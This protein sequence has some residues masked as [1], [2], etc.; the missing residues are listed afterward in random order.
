MRMPSPEHH[1]L[2]TL[3]IELTVVAALAATVCTIVMLE[4]RRL[5]EWRGDVIKGRRKPQATASVRNETRLLTA[6]CATLILIAAITF[7]TATVGVIN[8]V[9]GAVA[10]G[11][12]EHEE[13]RLPPNG[14]AKEPAGRQQPTGPG[15]P[16]TDGRNR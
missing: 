8:H 9:E 7:V 3:A 13:P 4:A 16:D 14:D 15:N 5:W 1:Y 11:A 6:V 10:D 2:L 12:A